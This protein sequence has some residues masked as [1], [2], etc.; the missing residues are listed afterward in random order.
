MGTG[1]VPRQ[2]WAP[3]FLPEQIFDTVK[4]PGHILALEQCPATYG[5]CKGVRAHLG[6]N[7][8]PGHSWAPEGCQNVYV[9]ICTRT[10]LLF[11]F[12][13]GYLFFAHMC[14]GTYRWLYILGLYSSAHICPDTIPVYFG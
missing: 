7:R 5:H 6:N 8:V 4:V 2:I 10:P 14:L 3:E 11:P 12:V 1:R 13:P 9:P